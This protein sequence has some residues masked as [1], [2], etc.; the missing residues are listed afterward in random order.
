MTLSFFTVVFDAD[1]PQLVGRFW[2]A[3]LERELTEGD[4]GEWATLP[5]DP[6]IDFMKVPEGKTTKNRMHLDWSVTDREPEVQRLLGL[7]ATRLWDVKEKVGEED[8]EWTA[9]ADSEGNEFCVIQSD[10]PSDRHLATVVL[11]SD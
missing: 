11:D 7:G 4:P 5:G 6:R 1:D 10:P 8:M 9:L 2:A 3:A